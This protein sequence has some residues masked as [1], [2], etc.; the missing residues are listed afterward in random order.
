MNI[1]KMIAGTMRFVASVTNTNLNV[2]F[3]S[4]FRDECDVRNFGFKDP[5]NL[6]EYFKWACYEWQGLK[7][8]LY[9]IGSITE[10]VAGREITPESPSFLR[11][12]KQFISAT[13][14]A[15]NRGAKVILLAAA[16]KRLFVKGELEALFPGVVFTLGDNFTG[17]LIIKR[18]EQV[19]R[20]YEIDLHNSR[21][22]VI[23]P[24]GLL[25]T[26]SSN[27]LASVQ[28]CKVVGLGNPKRKNL[29]EKMSYMLSPAYS[30]QEVSKIGKI[31]LVIAC[32]SSSQVLLTSERVDMIQNGRKL[33]VVDPAEPYAMPEKC[34]KDCKGKV[35]RI[36]AGN[37]YSRNLR[38]TPFPFGNLMWRLLRLDEGVTWGCFCEAWLTAKHLRENPELAGI[39]WDIT[40]KNIRLIEKYYSYGSFDGFGLP[41]ISTCFNKP[42]WE[43][44]LKR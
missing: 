24:Y 37:G 33:V 16:T 39:G 34:F 3:V 19:A 11:G 42:I 28:G 31:D 26:V 17:L 4:T 13:R 5:E 30:Y 22:L 23:G 40:P 35:I 43:T 20:R 38:Y 8:A 12:R 32:N 7:G 14:D 10:H 6:P 15:V 2:G 9:M 29:L 44:S 25:G 1:N 18:I 27:Y 41:P 21:V 36:D